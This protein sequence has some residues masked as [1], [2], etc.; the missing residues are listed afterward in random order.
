MR[1]LVPRRSRA[2]LA[3]LAVAAVLA[4]S[5]FAQLVPFGEPIPVWVPE[6]P[7]AS[8]QPRVVLAEDG[9]FAVVWFQSAPLPGSGSLW[10]RAFS[11]AGA[12][13]GEP[14]R[15]DAA[16]PVA[17]GDGFDVAGDGEGNL[18]VAWEPG[19]GAGAVYQRLAPDGSP[20]GPPGFVDTGLTPDGGRVD[21]AGPPQVAL[22]A[23]GTL[24]FAWEQ[25]DFEPV[26]E[27]AYERVVAQREGELP[28]TVG[29]SIVVTLGELALRDRD[30]AW[31]AWEHH[32]GDFI[33]SANLSHLRFG[34]GVTTRSAVLEQPLVAVDG[35]GSVLL[36]GTQF[37]EPDSSDGI[38]SAALARL[39][40]ATDLVEVAP[41]PAGCQLALAVDGAGAGG[42][43]VTWGAGAGAEYGGDSSQDG[44]W[45]R[46]YLSGGLPQGDALR[47]G[48]EPVLGEVDAA[49]EGGRAVVVRAF[50][51]GSAGLEVLR[52]AA[53][54]VACAPGERHLCLGDGRFRVDV[55]W[56]NPYAGPPENRPVGLGRP[57]PL[58][59]DTGAFWFF[60]PGNLELML[61]VLDGRPVNG[62]WWVF[63]AGLTTVEH[64]IQVS[65]GATG[66]QARYHNPP[67]VIESRA[68]VAA[69]DG[70]AAPGT[71]GA[72]AFAVP[73][74]A[75]RGEQTA[76]EIPACD[77]PGILCLQQDRFA[78]RLAWRDPRSGDTGAGLARTITADTGSFWFFRPD[79]LELMVKV[80]DGRP[81]NGHWWV[82]LG[83][84]SDVEYTLEVIDRE[85]GR[86][87]RYDNPPY[88]LG[89]RADTL[90]F[91]AD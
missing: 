35:A 20:V 63:S 49:Y 23:D 18:A 32:A 38:C 15:I 27:L 55:D 87:R 82:F 67:L 4:P 89:S 52:L 64:W 56:R 75:A 69:F 85:T 86:L 2:V 58:T 65:D 76:G 68:D 51:P 50:G 10:V 11:A 34:T 21:D 36:V 80:L 24:V 37:G 13:L 30:E 44:L 41:D 77:D 28:T 57:H 60:R 73:L 53:P 16:H 83:S 78:L 8:L 59:A 6:E 84:L 14:R 43:L 88:V 7:S 12:P 26:Q 70:A 1:S 46:A 5:A 22:A 74:D 45:V 71:A 42:F 66:E 90:A 39:S 17:G 61:K 47:L 19:E 9:R 72:V 48:P 91:A 79:N 54:P 3:A 81:V 31:I 33:V 40:G 29:T 25:G 62:H